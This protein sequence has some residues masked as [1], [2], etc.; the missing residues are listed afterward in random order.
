MDSLIRNLLSSVEKGRI[1]DT[2]TV[3]DCEDSLNS[4]IATRLQD[5]NYISTHRLQ[6]FIAYRLHSLIIF[7]LP[8]RCIN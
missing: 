6:Q 1:V 5:L 8:A 3:S 2:A 4:L 7:G